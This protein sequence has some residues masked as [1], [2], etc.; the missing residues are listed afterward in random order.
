MKK[1]T[2]LTVF[3]SS[4]FVTS[5]MAES[6][7]VL[8]DNITQSSQ[9]IVNEIMTMSGATDIQTA[10]KV[11]YSTKDHQ[12][13]VLDSD[14]IINNISDLTKDKLS[15][16]NSIII[17]GS[18]DNNQ[19]VAQHLLGYGSKA[20]YLVIKG[21]KGDKGIEL[22]RFDNNNNVSLRGIAQSL[23]KNAIK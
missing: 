15:H 18:A 8:A 9:T 22:I 10:E 2:I 12:I 1:F 14:L 5:A 17:T 19:A 23:V 4:L 16:A 7:Y 6:V 13:V 21:L 11:L 20:D 3:T